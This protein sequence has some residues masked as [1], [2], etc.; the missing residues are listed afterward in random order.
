MLNLA[1]VNT[2]K[3]DQLSFLLVIN[4][5]GADTP[6][7]SGDKQVLCS[8]NFPHSVASRTAGAVCLLS[9]DDKFD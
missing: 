1:L 4:T 6:V 2:K 8:P 9:Q 3:E 5:Y 7:Y